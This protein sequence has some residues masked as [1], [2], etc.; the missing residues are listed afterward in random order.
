MEFHKTLNLDLWFDDSRLKREV[1][2][3]LMEIAK[4]FYSTLKIKEEPTD[5]TLTGSSANYNYTEHSDIDLHLIIDVSNVSCD[6]ELTKDYFLAKKSL[7]NDK[8]DIFIFKR[9]V[10]LYIQDSK[11]PHIS[12]GV[13]SLL[14]KE[15]IIK[16]DPI[17]NSKVEIDSE[18]F[19]K[20]LK[21]Y[22]DL[23][24]HNLNK[25][26]NLKFL[27]KIRKKISE[28]RREGLATS[29]GQYSI[30][31]LVFKKLR[32]LGYLDKLAKLETSLIDKEFS[33]ESF[34][35]WIKK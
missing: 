25:K 4:S 34:K 13:Y 14:H 12:T 16:P 27:S 10:E 6:E 32:D 23:V 19:N 29:A 20:K 31:N 33:L 26:T 8:H 22:K 9:P 28:M 17:L 2:E 1:Q 30:E 15:W 21:E 35:H 24:E 5:I 3:K 18:L 11:E 7:W